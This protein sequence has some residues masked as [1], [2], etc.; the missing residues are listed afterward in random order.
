MS[1]EAI[2]SIQIF[3]IELARWCRTLASQDIFISLNATRFFVD[4]FTA[5]AIDEIDRFL[6]RI[7]VVPFGSSVK[8]TVSCG[9]RFI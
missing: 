1:L 2:L 8:T 5:P 7:T 6:A 9:L 3:D 4:D